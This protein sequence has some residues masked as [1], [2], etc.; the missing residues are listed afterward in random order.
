MVEYL[1]SI[2]EALASTSITK[3]NRVK[4]PARNPNTQEMEDGDQKFKAIPGYMSIFDI[5][6]EKKHN[7]EALQTK[8]SVIQIMQQGLED[9]THTVGVHGISEVREKQ[10]HILQLFDSQIPELVLK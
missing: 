6:K 4:V 7:L 5:K 3:E 8:Q 10:V 2:H 1:G 9:A